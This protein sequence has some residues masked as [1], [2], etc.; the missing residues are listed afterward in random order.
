MITG[1]H[2]T[3]ETKRKLSLAHQGMKYKPMSEEGRRNISLSQV[4]HTPWNK[5]K[6]GIYSE[7]TLRKIG[8]AGKLQKGKKKKPLSEDT[9]RKI[10]IVNMGKKL[11]A[12]Q[13]KKIS[14]KMKLHKITPEH[15]INL[16]ASRKGEKSCRWRGGI[17]PIN[18]RIRHS[19]EF[20]LWRES[21]FAR[22]NYT[23]QK[24]QKRGGGIH[25]HHIK[26]FSEYPELR[27]AIDNGVTLCIKCHALEHP[28]IGFFNKEICKMIRGG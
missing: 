16:S 17:S 24:C 8:E 20:R 1:S 14:E 15:R 7:E 25:P 18:M 13:K 26:S 6:T 19:I 21:V 22:D 11:T 27:F 10:S 4:G 3:K 9:K 5:G 12:E 2:H 28:Q 23:C